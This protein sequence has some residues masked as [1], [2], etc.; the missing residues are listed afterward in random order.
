MTHPR[1]LSRLCAR[2]VVDVGLWGGCSDT[3]TVPPQFCTFGS[4]LVTPGCYVFDRRL[5]R[6]CAA[7]GSMLEQHLSQHRW[8]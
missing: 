5:D 2:W 7:L 3:G 4:R 1:V 8:R 6:F